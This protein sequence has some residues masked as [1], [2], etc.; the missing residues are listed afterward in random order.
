MLISMRTTV[1][2]DDSLLR[3]AKR[4][5]AER[6][7][8]LSDVINHALRESLGR[9][10]PAPGPFAMITYGP[11]STRADHEPSAFAAA[12]EDEDRARLR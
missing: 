6:C 7:V 9:P 2:L 12:I 1:V 10:A 5:A 8:T 3:Q 11:A 4:L